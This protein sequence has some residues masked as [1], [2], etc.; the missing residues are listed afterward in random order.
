MGVGSTLL[1]ILLSLGAVGV[2]L[3]VAVTGSAMPVDTLEQSNEPVPVFWTFLAVTDHIVISPSSA[4]IQAGSSQGFTV[5]AF[6]DPMTSA[7]DV[8][9][10]ATFSITDGSC[11]RR[12]LHGDRAGPS[13]RDGVVRR[14][15]RIRRR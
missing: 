11:C 5:E 2:V 4:T 10:S 8:T 7:G 12:E 3:A 9:S 15:R 1:K 14:R 13:H 6:S